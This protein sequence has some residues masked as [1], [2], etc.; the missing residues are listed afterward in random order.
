MINFIS[1]TNIVSFKAVKRFYFRHFSNSINCLIYL[2]LI[3]CIICLKQTFLEFWPIF[4]S[5]LS[6]S[7]SGLTQKRK[8]KGDHSWQIVHVWVKSESI[9]LSRARMTF[10]WTDLLMS[11]QADHCLIDLK[12]LLVHLT[13]MK[14]VENS[15]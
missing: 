7:I 4:F 13:H 2:K 3:S 15:S 9:E 12:P 8:L 6:F 5:N 11:R 1:I 10:E 14:P